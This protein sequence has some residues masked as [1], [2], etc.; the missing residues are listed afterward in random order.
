MSNTRTILD[1]ASREVGAVHGDI[2]LVLV[3]ERGLTRERLQQWSRRL[4]EQAESLE[5]LS[6]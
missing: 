6:Q 4:R 2:A 3:A 5:T 1:Q